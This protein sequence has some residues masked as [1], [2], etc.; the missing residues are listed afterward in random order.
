MKLYFAITVLLA[1]LCYQVSAL[2]AVVP[3]DMHIE[4]LRVQRVTQELNF[5][6]ASNYCARRQ[7]RLVTLD[8]DSSNNDM[9]LLLGNM[10]APANNKDKAHWIGL[11]NE[12]RNDYY[13]TGTGNKIGISQFKEEEQHSGSKGH[14][15]KV[16]K[17]VRES[18]T[19]HKES[20]YAKLQFF[21]QD[22][23]AILPRSS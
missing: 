2:K 7:M 18:L 16:L 21:C 17:K 8:T 5:Y 23:K 11:S 20:C 13:W 15:V 9:D 10:D 4:G 1:G 22:R 3:E 19:W 6:E 12:N 14:C